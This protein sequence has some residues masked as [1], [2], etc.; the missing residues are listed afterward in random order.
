MS[1]D[2]KSLFGRAKKASTLE[3]M[4]MAQAKKMC[5]PFN[6]A[7]NSYSRAAKMCGSASRTAK[8]MFEAAAQREKEL[9]S[10]KPECALTNQLMS[11]LAMA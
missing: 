5:H 4:V 8:A 11:A 10:K 2:F 3:I 1:E 7:I 6:P 9:E